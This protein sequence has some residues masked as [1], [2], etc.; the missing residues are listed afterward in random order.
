MI[1]KHKSNIGGAILLGV[2]LLTSCSLGQGSEGS[3]TTEETSLPIPTSAPF[4]AIVNGE[5]ILLSEYEG[6]LQRYQAAMDQIGSP[7]DPEKAKED[8]LNDLIAQ[9]LFTQSA[10]SQ[11]Y[12]HSE[13]DLQAKID[14]YS[15]ASGGQEALQIWMAENYYN[16]DSFRTAVSREMAMIWMRNL[17][18]EQVPQTAEQIHARQILVDNENE[19]IGIQRQLE[20]GTPFKTLAFQYEPETGGELGWFPRGYLL[21]QDIENA[22]FSLQ[23]GQYSGIIPTS[24]GFHLI[25]VIEVDPQHPL[26]QDAL[27]LIQRKAIE[28]WLDDAR[29][30]SKVEILVP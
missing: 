21:Q 12:S 23:P 29:A 20:A 24:F 27:Q 18:I 22:A 17:L 6:E 4:A 10:A 19:A 9:T 5:G 26:S 1:K 14:Q 13:A 30:Q 11:N 25:E 7:F 2:V 3:K 16:Q 15:E 28:S 8:V